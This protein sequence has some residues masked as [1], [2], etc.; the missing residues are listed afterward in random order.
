MMRRQ[1][2]SEIK[3]ANK[4]RKLYNKSYNELISLFV[5]EENYIQNIWSFWRRDSVKFYIIPFS[6]INCSESRF[7]FPDFLH[8]LPIRIGNSICLCD[9]CQKKFE[10]VAKNLFKLNSK[11]IHQRDFAPLLQYYTVK[12]KEYFDLRENK[13]EWNIIKINEKTDGI[14]DLN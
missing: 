7:K 1:V 4:N 11:P 8:S 6:C 3:V 14:I 13:K 12:S 5:K 2:F 9:K 10:F